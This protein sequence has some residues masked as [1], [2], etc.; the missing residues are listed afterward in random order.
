MVTNMPRGF[1]AASSSFRRARISRRPVELAG[2]RAQQRHGDRHEEGRGDALPAHVA[3]RHHQPVLG[4]AQHLE[5]I[6]AHVPRRLD[7]GV[8]VEP[9]APAG[10]GEVGREDPHLDLAGDREV[11]L[12]GGADRVG[13]GLRL[14]QRAHPRLHLQDLERLGEVV[15]RPQLEAARLVLDVLQRAQEHDGDLAGGGVR[16][17]PPAHLV[18]VDPGHHDVEQQQVRGAPL[19]RAQRRFP[20]QGDAQLEVPAQGLHQHVHVGLDVVHDQHAALRQLLDG[21]GIASDPLLA[22]GAGATPRARRR[23]RRR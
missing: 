20:V 10:R 15:V 17:Q 8:D 14:Q 6:A 3:D 18:A 7:R 4:H 1:C 23:S 5:E 21:H 12:L 11:P 22:G 2:Q 9:H 16:A 19:H 13:V